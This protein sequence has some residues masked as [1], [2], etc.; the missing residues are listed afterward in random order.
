M[1]LGETKGTEDRKPKAVSA[2]RPRGG[3]GAGPPRNG[4]PQCREA[5]GRSAGGAGHREKGLQTAEARTGEGSARGKGD[6][7][8][9]RR[10]LK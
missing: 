7:N 9:K 5:G 2:L 10:G 1:R 8:W 4:K 6:L 3:L